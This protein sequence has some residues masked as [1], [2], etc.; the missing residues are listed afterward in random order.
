MLPA[1]IVA[2]VQDILQD[3]TYLGYINDGDIMLGV[4]EGITVFPSIVIEVAGDRLLDESYPYEGRAININIIGY[5]QVFDKD[6]Q[7]VGDA[8][9]KGVLDIENDIRKAVSADITLGLSDVYDTRL[10]ATV[11]DIDQYPVRGFAVSVEVHY[12]QNRL[13]R[14]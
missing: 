5:I 8:N 14:L 3:S 11:Q 2:T 13:T 7:L 4:R 9:T 6:K 1:T 12:R 10:L